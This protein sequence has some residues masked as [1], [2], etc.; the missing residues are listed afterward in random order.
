MRTRLRALLGALQPSELVIPSRGLDPATS[1][2]LKAALTGVRT[3]TLEPGEQFW[4]PDK[5][6]EEIAAAGYLTGAATGKIVVMSD[7]SN[8]VQ[9][10]LLLEA[11]KHFFLQGSGGLWVGTC[12]SGPKDD[13]GSTSMLI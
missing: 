5:T 13:Y 7:F 9:M 4:G 1:K 6:R 3:N 2:V 10:Y 11:I 8:R 12:I